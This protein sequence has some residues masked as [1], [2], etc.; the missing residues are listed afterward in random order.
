M[1]TCEAVLTEACWLMGSL[2]NGRDAVLEFVSRGALL[3]AFG[4][5]DEV[6]PLSRLLR[7][8]SSVPM[9]LADACL[10]R[11]SELMP[12]ATILTVDSDFKIYRKHRDAP[13]RILTPFD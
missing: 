3:T 1:L 8:Y 7:K 13:I 6:A 11:M 9:D 10:V 12:R 5:A 4:V 2:P